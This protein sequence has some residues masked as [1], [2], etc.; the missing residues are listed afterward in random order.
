MGTTVQLTTVDG[1]SLNAY[2]AEP[3]GSTKG[4][5]VVIQE[6]FG[7][8]DH[9]RNV[10]DGYAEQGYLAIAPA[11]FDRVRPGVELEYDQDGIDV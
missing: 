9:I 11:L 8:N 5:V 7:V 6:I 3:D 1:N 4:A 2:K 10:T